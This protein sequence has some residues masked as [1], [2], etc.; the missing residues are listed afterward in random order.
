MCCRLTCVTV[1][2]KDI[3]E[4]ISIR[5]TSLH[6]RSEHAHYVFIHCN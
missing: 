3:Q 6:I 2:S 4:D 5:S 1:L